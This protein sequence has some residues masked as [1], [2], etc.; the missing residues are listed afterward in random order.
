MDRYYL[1]YHSRTLVSLTG[2][3]EQQVSPRPG[4]MFSFPNDEA[5]IALSDGVKNINDINLHTGMNIVVSVNVDSE[6]NAIEISKNLTETIL[7]LITF[8]TLTYCSPANLLSVMDVAEKEPHLFTHY[9]YPF[10]AQE[11]IGIVVIIDENLFGTIFK[12]YDKASDRQRIMRALTWLRN[13]IGEEKTVDKFIS[14]WVGLEVIKHILRRNLRTKIRNPDEWAGVEDI[15]TNELHFQNFDAVKKDGRNGLLHGFRE[16]D[17]KFVG[18]IASYLEPVRKTLI[19]CI[20]SV[21]GLEDSVTMTISSKTPRGIPKGPWAIIKGEVR[22]LTLP[23][24]EVVKNYPTID[25]EVTNKEFSIDENG[26][27]KLKFKTN[28][29]FHGS[30]GTKWEVKSL[31]LWGKKDAGIGRGDIDQVVSS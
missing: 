2:R 25:A 18:E 20:G 30:S 13:G 12:D 16:L 11:I 28:H 4:W 22:N 27:L 1:H 17:D 26:E 19:F 5:R 9:A 29:R 31:E 10:D 6:R 23:F 24:E 3:K 15:F 14:Y 7:N 21:L 8:S